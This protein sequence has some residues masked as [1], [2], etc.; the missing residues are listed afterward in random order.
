M[1]TMLSGKSVGIVL[2]EAK[3]MVEILFFLLGVFA[4][5]CLGWAVFG[6]TT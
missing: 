6:K 4:G 3:K 5:L 1:Q 2:G